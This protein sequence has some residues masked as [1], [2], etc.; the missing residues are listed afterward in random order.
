MKTLWR[1][2]G[3]LRPYVLVLILALLLVMLGSALGVVQPL[4]VRWV[5]DRVISERRSNLLGLGALF[6][7]GIALVRA[8]LNFCQR[9]AMEYMAQKAVFDLRNALYKRMQQLSY[10]FYDK[11]ETGQ[12]MSRLVGDVEACQRF[13]GMGLIQTTT[14]LLTFCAIVGILFW[15]NLQ[16]ALVALVFMPFL[17][18]A[19]YVYGTRVRPLFWQV[20]EQMAHLT[21]SLQQSL[22]GIRVVKAFAREE[23][24]YAKFDHESREY[25]ARNLKAVRMQ[26]FYGPYMTFLGG[27]ASALVIFF[28][29]RLVVQQEIS[30]GTLVAFN[31]YV[32]QMIQPVRMLGMLIGLLQRSTSAAERVFE[33]MDTPVQVSDRPGAVVLP[34]VKGDVCFEHVS[35]SYDGST[36]VLDGLSLCVKAGETVAILGATGSGKS[37]LIHLIPRFY[38]VTGGSLKIDGHDVRSVTLDSLRTQVGIVTQETFLFSASIK[39]NIAFGRPD[40]SFAE[41]QAAAK[42]AHIHDFI[43]TLPRG[44]DSV[45]G[46]R[47]AGLSGGQKQR[48][49]IARALLMDARIVLL[50]ESTSNVDVQTEM[51]IQ[52]A[53]RSLLTNRTSFIIAQRLST[54]RSASRIVVLQHGRIEEHGTHEELMSRN[55]LY[56]KIYELQFG[57][58]EVNVAAAKGGGA[59]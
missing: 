27:A 19:L 46:E 37:T 39:Q 11:A 15:M 42:A 49:A 38:D 9:Y 54:V 33:I 12:L 53:F 1:L 44:Y 45:I 58:Q 6:V 35:F 16:L 40:A 28:G 8:V 23:H 3:Y 55:G 56:K 20:Q 34:K 10:S 43:M 30:L 25:M 17:I 22:T 21:T 32:L 24:E 14:H 52:Q 7:L 57:A 5:I 50:D 31:S 13:L 29:G 51:R 41:I 48:L 47:G 36:K 26:A 18:R 59:E 2:L 4:V